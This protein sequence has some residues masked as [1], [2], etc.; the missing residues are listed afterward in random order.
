[1]VQWLK[2]INKELQVTLK[3]LHQKN[4]AFKTHSIEVLSV[5]ILIIHAILVINKK[6]KQLMKTGLLWK[7]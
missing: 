7:D 6:L 3:V 4:G 1:M 5:L 2:E